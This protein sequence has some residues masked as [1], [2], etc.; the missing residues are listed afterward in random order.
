LVDGDN[1]PNA[2]T[3]G[4]DL[5]PPPLP[6]NTDLGF[7]VVSF[8]SQAANFKAFQRA[9]D[10]PWFYFVHAQ[11][12]AK[13]AADHVLTGTAFL[14][15][16]ISDVT[17]PILVLSRDGFA[18]ETVETLKTLEPERDI[19]L[20]S[21]QQFGGV[22]QKL[23]AE[24]GF[25]IKAALPAASPGMQQR[26]EYSSF[27]PA[28]SAPA[29][30][31]FSYE[32]GKD[33]PAPTPVPARSKTP[34]PS[35]P[36]REQRTGPVSA[37]VVSLFAPQLRAPGPSSAA[38]LLPRMTPQ[39]IYRSVAEAEGVSPEKLVLPRDTAQPWAGYRCKLCGK[40]GGLPDSHWEEHCPLSDTASVGSSSSGSSA[41]ADRTR[42]WRDYV[43]PFCHK[44]GG[45]PESHYHWAC[46][47]YKGEGLAPP[48][49]P[50]YVIETPDGR[51]EAP[52][53]AASV[54]CQEEERFSRFV[55]ILN[56]LYVQRDILEVRLSTL[57]VVMRENFVY[58]E[59]A[60]L[61]P[62]VER[63]VELG[64]GERRGEQGNAALVLLK[65]R[66]RVFVAAPAVGSAPAI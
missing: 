15:N 54:W 38:S 7:L 4:L 3:I 32:P 51:A 14:A 27:D 39:Q 23:G 31:R 65:E 50:K 11:T 45:L 9:V 44:P 66:I 53:D 52:P 41:A 37:P 59:K 36:A 19:R 13:D 63:A 20:I 55:A 48:V 49:P 22:L 26:V 47:Q 2:P 6:P 40:D 61:K 16:E 56:K 46:P 57:G 25:H 8:V 28:A 35:Q 12:N 62:L 10:Q 60:G 34:P 1:F 33:E 24:A 43:C 5:F 30:P 42:P 29:G 18:R 58:S 21:P 17:S 64:L